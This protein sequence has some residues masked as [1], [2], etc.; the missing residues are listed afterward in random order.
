MKL[1]TLICADCGKE[2]K[3]IGLAQKRCK[4][5]SDKRRKER[6]KNSQRKYRRKKKMKEIFGGIYEIFK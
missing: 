5:C 3:R 4:S 2:V 6:L 1:G